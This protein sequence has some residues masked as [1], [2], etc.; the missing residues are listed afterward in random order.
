MKSQKE[1][2]SL[3]NEWEKSPNWELEN[4]PGYEEHHDELLK[5]RQKKQQEWEFL[6]SRKKINSAQSLGMTLSLYEEWQQLKK[7]SEIHRENATTMLIQL[8]YDT[9]KID[10]EKKITIDMLLESIF[11]GAINHAKAE[12]IKEHS[13]SFK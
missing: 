10:L 1:I 2:I 11:R 3:I 4:T 12:L 5:F 7:L 9:T 6:K 13:Y 8:I